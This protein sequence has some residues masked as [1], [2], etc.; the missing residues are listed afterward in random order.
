[1][2]GEGA[3]TDMSSSAGQSVTGVEMTVKSLSDAANSVRDF[4]ENPTFSA[5]SMIAIAFV[6][7]TVGA[8]FY[9]V[10]KKNI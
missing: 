1:M 8:L 3:G 9:G 6:I 4:L 5:T 2:S 7:F 10:R